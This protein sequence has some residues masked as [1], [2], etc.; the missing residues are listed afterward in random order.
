M[1]GRRSNMFGNAAGH[2]PPSKKKGKKQK[3]EEL[4][5]NDWID[6]F[7]KYEL[8]NKALGPNKR[9]QYAKF[10]NSEESGPKF[11]ATQVMKSRFSRDYPKFRN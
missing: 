5:N 2:P 11:S 1:S 7:E 6:M 4:T 9:L 10:L 3:K 8:A